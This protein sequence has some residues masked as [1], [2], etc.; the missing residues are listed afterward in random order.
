MNFT[1]EAK[2]MGGNLY[3]QDLRQNATARN[4]EKNSRDCR[5]LFFAHLADKGQG[6]VQDDD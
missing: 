3:A 4:A 1:P 6:K 2:R 5:L